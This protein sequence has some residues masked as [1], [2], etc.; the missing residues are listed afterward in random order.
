MTWYPDLSPYSY[1]PESVH[2]GET[3]L[4]VGWLDSSHDFPVGDPPGGF[5]EALEWLCEGDAHARTRG[6]HACNLPHAQQLDYPYTI[7][8]DGNKIT[9]GSAEVRVVA[10]DGTMLSAPNLIL[11]YVKDHNYLPPDVF[12]EA[13][14]ARRAVT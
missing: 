9:L 10:K 11:H 8:V 2:P 12:T 1:M 5:L 7:E 13:V 6:W 3:I 4:N 14:L